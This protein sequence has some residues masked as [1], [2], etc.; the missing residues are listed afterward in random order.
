[1]RRQQTFK[2][3]SSNDISNIWQSYNSSKEAL[4]QLN[5]NEADH[6]FSL[7]QPKVVDFSTALRST[8]DA[9]LDSE[10]ILRCVE[11]ITRSKSPIFDKND[12]FAKSKLGYSQN[13][14][15][16]LVK[17]ASSSTP[18]FQISS[19]ILSIDPIVTPVGSQNIATNSNNPQ[20][21]HSIPTKTTSIEIHQMQNRAEPS[22]SKDGGKTIQ[23][24]TQLSSDTSNLVQTPKL[25]D[26]SSN[27]KNRPT[28]VEAAQ[29]RNG[30][31]KRNE[32]LEE[33]SLKDELNKDLILKTGLRKNGHFNSNEKEKPIVSQAILP[34]NTEMNTSNTKNVDVSYENPGNVD[35]NHSTVKNKINSMEV[36]AKQEAENESNEN[37]TGGMEIGEKTFKDRGKVVSPIKKNGNGTKP[38]INENG[39]KQNNGHDKQMD[40]QANSSVEQRNPLP[41][42]LI[43]SQ[44]IPTTPHFN[45]IQSTKL[46]AFITEL[47][48]SDETD[49]DQISIGA[50]RALKSPDDYW[51]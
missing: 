25:I 40:D 3:Q 13:N 47:S 10:N 15:P 24:R 49:L 14:P 51:I 27:G 31:H 7:P 22:C 39:S 38:N 48:D 33:H 4:A 2:Q 30:S 16:A 23:T 26:T 11:Q 1:M 36:S 35:R 6:H 28:Q 46:S 5:A 37:S 43:S 18:F 21:G 20:N 50:A 17:F 32:V 45:G 44:P 8:R 41:N 34:P 9:Y 12:L 29:P 42:V 19:N